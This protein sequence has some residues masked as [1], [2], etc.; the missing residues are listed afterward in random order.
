[1]HSYLCEN[2]HFYITMFIDMLASVSVEY[3]GDFIPS[4]QVYTSV[5]MLTG[6]S[7]LKN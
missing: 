6:L 4:A 5:C 7:Y 2:P 3:L 1:M